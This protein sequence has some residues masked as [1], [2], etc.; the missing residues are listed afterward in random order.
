MSKLSQD[1]HVFIEDKR[2]EVKNR[3]IQ[4]A[5]FSSNGPFLKSCVIAIWSP[6][7]RRLTHLSLL[8]TKNKTRSLTT[9]SETF[10]RRLARGV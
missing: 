10:G 9:V 3:A 7:R 5:R 8:L 2:D 4:T 6:F 1:S